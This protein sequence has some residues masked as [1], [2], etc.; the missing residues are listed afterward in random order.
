MQKV[1]LALNLPILWQSYLAP[2]GPQK[3]YQNSL[4]TGGCAE[5]LTNTKFLWLIVVKNVAETTYTFKR[6]PKRPHSVALSMV[7]PHFDLVW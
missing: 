5:I 3:F 1:T 7:S 6:L 2:Q 4:L